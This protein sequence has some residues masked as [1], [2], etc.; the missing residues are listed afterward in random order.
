MEYLENAELEE[1]SSLLSKIMVG[2]SYIA[3]KL[4][5]FSSK[6]LHFRKHSKSNHKRKVISGNEIQDSAESSLSAFGPDFNS[7][8]V[9]EGSYLQGNFLKLEKSLTDESFG[10]AI[11]PRSPDF[12]QT[13]Y[14]NSDQELK[15]I[16]SS[17]FSTVLYNHL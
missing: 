5:A 9:F 10:S 13:V 11:S 4:E 17:S 16:R 1:L 2:S 14:L 8:N 7:S 15:R 12:R 6:N 3:G